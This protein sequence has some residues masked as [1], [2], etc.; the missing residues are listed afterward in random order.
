MTHH[1]FRIGQHVCLVRDGL[2]GVKSGPYEILRALVNDGVDF[3]YH[4][5][6]L[7]DGH[8]RMVRQSEILEEVPT[9]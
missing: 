5:R 1:K 3:E 7:A 8:Q 4:V 9:V 2:F 6:H